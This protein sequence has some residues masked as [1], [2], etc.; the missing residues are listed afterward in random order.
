MALA[1][2]HRLFKKDINRLFKRGKTV[3]N[4]FF[5]IRFLRNDANYLRTA[6]IVSTKIVK[7]ATARNRIKRIFTEAICSG[8]FLEKSYDIAI[9]ATVSI[10][11][12]QSKEINRDLEQ[13][14]NKILGQSR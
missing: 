10:V 7:K 11:G 13:T 12:K 1:K 3:K 8:H 6:V 5:F 2:K 4:S 9:V 14:L